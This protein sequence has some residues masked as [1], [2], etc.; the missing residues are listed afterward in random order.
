[1]Q[2]GWIGDCVGLIGA[3]MEYIIKALARSSHLK[4][5]NKTMQKS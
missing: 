3:T 5:A 2:V 4:T 1:M